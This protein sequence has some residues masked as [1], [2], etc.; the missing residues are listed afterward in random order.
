MFFLK[1]NSLF[2]FIDRLHEE[3]FFQKISTLRKKERIKFSGEK[4]K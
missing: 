2:D 3:Q 4:H 1:K